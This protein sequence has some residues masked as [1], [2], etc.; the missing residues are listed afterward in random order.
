LAMF[1]YDAIST[2]QTISLPVLVV[3]GKQ[4]ILIKKRACSYITE[5]IPNAQ[6]VTLAPS[7]HMGVLERNAEMVSAVSAFAKATFAGTERA[8]GFSLK[9]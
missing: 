4:D 3:A 2:L 9:Q 5:Y 6:L 1:D 8:S 7:G